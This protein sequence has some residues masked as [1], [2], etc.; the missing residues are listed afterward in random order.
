MSEKSRPRTAFQPGQSGNPAGR[1][2]G[3][4]NKVT[5]EREAQ[6]AASGITPLDYML[7]VLRD[8][9]APTDRR[10]EM[11]R[12]AAPYCHPRM[13]PVQHTGRSGVPIEYAN[14]TEEE[15][16][17]RLADI[18]GPHANRRLEIEFVKTPSEIEG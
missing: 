2:K 16:D 5:R 12:A 11:A 17:A 6:I 9:N 7:S 4:P 10:D 8:E 1:P 13:A 15:I 3:V 14:L 18:L